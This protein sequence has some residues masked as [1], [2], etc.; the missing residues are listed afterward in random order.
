VRS[1]GRGQRFGFS[2]GS[3]PTP[4]SYAEPIFVESCSIPGSLPTGVFRVDQASYEVIGNV[5]TV[6]SFA[7]TF[8]APCSNG[9]TFVGT[10]S[11][12]MVNSTPSRG[13]YAYDAFGD[14]SG[15]G[16][17]SYLTYLGGPEFLNLNAPILSMATTPSGNGY[18]MMGADGGVFSYGD[19]NFYGSTGG[20]QLN[21]PAVGMAATPDGG[22]YWLVAS[23]GGIFSFGDAQFHGSMGGQALNQPVVGMANDP[24]T[25]G[26]CEVASDAGIFSY[27]PPFY[28]SLGGSGTSLIVGM[29]V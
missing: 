6:V 26:Y 5:T 28:G 4:G 9:E 22:G 15:F 24:A 7:V 10:L 11:Y 12:N 19:A 27:D 2:T 23:D 29:A 1:E 21:A 17:D 3:P 25:G 18:W 13:Y 20:M 8:I 16:N 14:L